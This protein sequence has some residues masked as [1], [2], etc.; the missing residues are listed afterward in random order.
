[1]I[2][3]FK[4]WDRNPIVT[5]HSELLPGPASRCF[6]RLELIRNGL[7]WIRNYIHSMCGFLE[8]QIDHV[9][10]KDCYVEICCNILQPVPTVL[11]LAS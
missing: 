7:K 4:I 10:H 3:A 2:S 1:M 8:W 6:S 9:L 5:C 11:V